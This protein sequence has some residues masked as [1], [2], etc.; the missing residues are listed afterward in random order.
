MKKFFSFLFAAAILFG[1]IGCGDD[2]VSLRDP[3]VESIET[4]VPAKYTVT[5]DINCEENLIF[6]KYDVTIYVGDIKIGMVNHGKREAFEIELEEGL[7]TIRFKSNEDDEVEGSTQVTVLKEATFKFKIACK[8]KKIE[9]TSI[10]TVNLTDEAEQLVTAPSLGYIVECLKHVPSIIG[11]EVDLEDNA[12]DFTGL[13]SSSGTVYFTSDLVELNDVSGDTVQK[14]G[15]SGG[16]SIDVFATSAE[17][18]ERN[19]Y[20]M[21]Y[22]DT[23]LDFGS[24]VVVGTIVIRISEKLSDEQQKELQSNIID[25]LLQAALFVYSI[26]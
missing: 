14:K 4:T 12:A 6:S 23:W 18:E 2:N 24:H 20:L 8:N 17:A 9:V 11:I 15:T 26:L 19:D 3:D 13:S 1:L 21:G 10:E 5:L 25:T 16:G 7:H 22:D